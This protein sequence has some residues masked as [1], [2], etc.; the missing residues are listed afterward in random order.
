MNFKKKLK[1]LIAG[2]ILLGTG[3][4]SCINKGHKEIPV[5]Y[6][7]SSILP[8]KIISKGKESGDYQAVPDAC[9]LKNSDIVVVFYSGDN[10]ITFPGE[11]YPNAGRICLVRSKDEGRTWSNPVIIY[12][13]VNDNRDPHIN[14][15]SDGSLICSFF[16]LKFDISDSVKLKNT[17]PSY[18]KEQI[19]KF[20]NNPDLL[21]SQKP[22][23]S[24]DFSGQTCKL[25]KKWTGLGP[26]VIKSYNN[27]KT[28]DKEAKSIPT[29]I[30]D[31]YCSAKVRELPDGICL[32]PVYHPE[33]S[34][35]TAWGGVIPS[36]DFGKTWG[37]VVPIGR[38]ADLILSSET[39]VILLR[40]KIL[41]AVMR[42]DGDKVNMHYSTSKD[43]GRSWQSINDLG[44]IGHA[45]SFTRL[46]TGEILLSYRAYNAGSGYYTGLRIS[47]DEAKSWE[48]PYLVDEKVG[49][50]PSTVELKD[51]TLLIIYYEEGDRSAIRALRFKK[52]GP[53]SE[54]EFQKPEQVEIVPF[55]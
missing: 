13:D 45:P 31:M 25:S 47:R 55:K 24:G 10:H 20:G 9:R 1:P 53:A 41:Y 54:K 26:F 18:T 28:W 2:F 16:S 33:P 43:M 46:M 29:S 48:G 8:Y 50:Y 6:S 44:F 52:P 5:P 22:I 34:G 37:K 14:Q 38:E 51:G 11:K 36:Y 12:D 27:G 23:Q 42:G 39:D 32:L 30:P 15:L 3:I 49:G 7:G 17:E 35:L 21:K 40:D 19:A 4:L